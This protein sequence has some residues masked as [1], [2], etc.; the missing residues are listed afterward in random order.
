MYFLVSELVVDRDDLSIYEKMA[1]VVLARYANNSAFDG[2]LSED[3][4]A[5]KMG[6]SSKEARKAIEQL[7][8][9]GLIG[10]EDVKT[11]VI[12]DGVD[13]ETYAFE[14]LH[15]PKKIDQALG[16]SDMDVLSKEI[17]TQ[18]EEPSASSDEIRELF[19]EVISKRQ[20]LILYEL[21]GRKLSVLKSAYETVKGQSPFDVIEAL[22]EYLQGSAS[23]KDLITPQITPQ[24]THEK[25]KLVNS[26]SEEEIDSLLIA[27][28]VKGTSAVKETGKTQVNLSRIH[29]LYQKQQSKK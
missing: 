19:E 2:L 11:K 1:C 26:V 20:A 27:L 14:S 10:Q 17:G 4:I 13:L 5:L 29:A 12:K 15:V 6:T 21:A 23:T 9:K 22:S 7:K 18:P 8:M 16:V 28:E 24:I 3:I 25:E